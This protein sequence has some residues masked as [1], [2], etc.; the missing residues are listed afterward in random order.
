[1]SASTFNPKELKPVAALCEEVG[2]P[3]AMKTVRDLCRTQKLPA[4]KIGNEW[5]STATAV[6]GYF[7]RGANKAFRRVCA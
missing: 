3:R 6:R 7:Y 5:M 4:V 1:M 2:V